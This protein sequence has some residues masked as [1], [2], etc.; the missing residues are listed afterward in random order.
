[1]SKIDQLEAKVA[2]NIDLKVSQIVS[3]T[4]QRSGNKSLQSHSYVKMQQSQE[5]MLCQT[6][7]SQEIGDQYDKSL[8]LTFENYKNSQD[9]QETFD[10][11]LLPD[12]DE[13]LQ[14]PVFTTDEHNKLVAEIKE[15]VKEA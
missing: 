3:M 1:M 4:S 8:E 11:Q 7:R 12:A 9:Y 14:M 2:Q 13:G 6:D 5:I 15:Q 10:N